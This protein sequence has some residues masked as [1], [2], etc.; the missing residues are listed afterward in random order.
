[1]PKEKKPCPPVSM[2]CA[3]EKV[4]SK[5][6]S[7]IVGKTPTVSFKK[8]K[9]VVV[10]KGFVVRKG[11][12]GKKTMAENKKNP[13]WVFRNS[14]KKEPIG[15]IVGPYIDVNDNKHMYTVIGEGGILKKVEEQK[16]KQQKP[17]MTLRR[18]ARGA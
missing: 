10:E 11:K 6:G 1:M 18:S 14:I 5:E 17:A 4:L 16:K 12:K 2:R 8:A 3:R 9:E 7:K 13:F 15:T